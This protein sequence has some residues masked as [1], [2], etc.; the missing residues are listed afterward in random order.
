MYVFDFEYFFLVAD[1][2]EHD[3]LQESV[4]EREPSGDYRAGDC[5]DVYQYIDSG[6]VL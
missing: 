6:G 1:T 3:C 2:G 5:G 4:R